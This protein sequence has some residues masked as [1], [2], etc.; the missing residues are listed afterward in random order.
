MI[1]FELFIIA[2]LIII[3]APGNDMIYVITQ[4]I[5]QGKSGE[6]MACLGVD[7]GSITLTVMAAFGIN[8]LLIGF[9]EMFLAI[10]DIGSLYLI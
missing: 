10:K 3:V 8:T 9:P 2:S 4:S 6:V 1:N 5:H 7:F